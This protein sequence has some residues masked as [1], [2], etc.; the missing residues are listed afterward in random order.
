MHEQFAPERAV[1]QQWAEGFLDRDGKFVQEFQTSFESGMWE[2]YLHAAL[3][4]WGLPV[5]MTHHAP[6][7]VVGGPQ[8]FTMEA[9]IAA[10][11]RGGK[12]AF[13]YGVSDIPN[14]F[15]Q[16]NIE[17]SIRICNSFTAKVKRYR[18][19]Y[20]KLPHVASKPF[21]IAIASFDRPL[22]H[23][24]AGRP[25]IAALYGLY[26][27][28]AATSPGATDI[29]SY[30]VSA[31]PKTEDVAIDLG[32]FCDEAYSEVSAVLY[33]SV[34][35]WGKV[36]ALADCPGAQTVYTTFHPRADSIMPVIRRTPKRAYVEH[37]HDGLMLLHN[38]FAKAPLESAT[39]AHPRIA[40]MRPALDGELV[41]EAPEDFLLV[42]MLE[43]VTLR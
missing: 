30:N 19:H 33:S 38:P 21:V 23:L 16:F 24:A 12:P 32:L 13:G 2:L 41:T 42:R 17:A 18:D 1:L 29:V 26:H 31:A 7:F 27:D 22:A 34:A 28:E 5:D 20:I 40:Q 10:P 6:D 14:D 39:L 35:T 43:S 15:T 36:R 25:V 4:E 9:T 8:P 37:L 3:K 11:A